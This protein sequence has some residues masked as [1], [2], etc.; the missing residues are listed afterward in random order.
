MKEKKKK[1]TRNSKSLTNIFGENYFIEKD[2]KELKDKIRNDIKKKLNQKAKGYITSYNIQKKKKNIKE[3]NETEKQSLFSKL[4]KDMIS[5]IIPKECLNIYQ[6]KFK[7]IDKERKQI[8]EKIILNKTK[9]KINEEKSQLLFITEKKDMNIIKKNVELNSK[10]IAMKK[11][12]NVIMKELK[13]T[14][15]GLN[16]IIEKYNQKKE[17]NDKL[18]NHWILLSDDIKNERIIIKK[19]KTITKNELED[20]NKWGNHIVYPNN[21]KSNNEETCE[22]NNV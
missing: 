12:I 22:N 7:T 18:K 11:K 4:E 6:D 5:Q 9:K 17:E 3:N 8:K 10:I 1:T 19:G 2:L 14:Q 20:I 16:S 15:K 13:S 21:K